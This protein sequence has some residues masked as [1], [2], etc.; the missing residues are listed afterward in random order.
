MHSMM[1]K[2]MKMMI[3]KPNY[4]KAELAAHQ[5]LQMNYVRELP[6]KVKKLIKPFPNL[7]IKKYSWFA[8]KRNM[9]H[10]E[11]CDFTGSDEGALYYLK[12]PN[13]STQYIILYNEKVKNKQRIRWT[14]AH[15]LG[16][17][18]LKHNELT[19]KTLLGRSTLTEKEYQV[20]ESEANCFARELLAPQTVIAKLG[21]INMF[22]IQNICEVSIEAA[23][24]V[25]KFLNKKI[26]KGYRFNFNKNIA[27]LFSEFI[28]K[29]VNKHHCN[30]CNRHFYYSNAK[31]CPFC[32]N[33]NI[34]KTLITFGGKEDMKY[35]GYEVDD[36][37]RAIECP[38]CGNEEVL[39]AGEHC[40]ICGIILINKC[41]TTYR[42]DDTGYYFNQESCHAILQGNARYCVHCG[43]ESTFYQQDLLEDW[44]RV[45]QQIEKSKIPF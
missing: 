30:I 15:E 44:S 42:A 18:M 43:N 4:R 22:D 41:A 26:E 1:T 5:L 38:Q 14:I 29:T 8:K 13:G 6:V 27:I 24:N 10:Q 3:S 20:F 11:V 21:K 19:N 35:D 33:E 40:M 23:S 36:M 17:Y 25:I 32:R 12:H 7:L 9:T 31:F 28:N 34:Y 45:Q 16:H 37:G 2:K 39:S